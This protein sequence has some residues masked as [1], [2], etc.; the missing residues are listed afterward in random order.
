MKLKADT[1]VRQLV[2]IE[3]GDGKGEAKV[4]LNA[5]TKAFFGSVTDSVTRT[6]TVVPKGFPYSLYAAGVI[7]YVSSCFFFLFFFRLISKSRPSIFDC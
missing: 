7:K 1:R 5:K 2:T 3:V 6:T 4:K